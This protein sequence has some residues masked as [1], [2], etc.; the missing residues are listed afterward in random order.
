MW[1]YGADLW[2]GA[3][4]AGAGAVACS[5]AFGPS[6]SFVSDFFLGIWLTLLGTAASARI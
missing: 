1:L 6:D 5:W 4:C 3:L 2:V